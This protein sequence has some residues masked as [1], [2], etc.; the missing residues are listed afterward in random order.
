MLLVNSVQTKTNFRIRI[1]IALLAFLLVNACT[2]SGPVD[3]PDWHIGDGNFYVRIIDVGQASSA[4]ITTPDGYH[5]I[6]DFATGT[7]ATKDILPLLDSLG[8]DIL[9]MAIVSHFDGDHISGSDEVLEV[10]DLAGYCYDHGGTYTTNNFL[11]YE[12]AVGDKRRTMNFGDTL[13]LGND[14]V[15]IA[16]MA[17]GGNGTFVIQENDKSVG[18]IISWEGFDVWIGGDLNGSD[19]GERVDMEGRIADIMPMVEFYV[20]NHHGSRYSSSET[21]LDALQPD[22]CAISCGYDNPYGHPHSETLARLAMWTSEIYRTDLSGT[23][24]VI[25]DDDGSYSISTEDGRYHEVF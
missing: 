14:G 4:L 7:A 19:E 11:E 5:L 12:E 21:F 9:D 24:T 25:V 1:L 18:C 10:I 15:R 17:S 2:D 13:Y 6:Y 20:A 23:I 3:P 8:I 16:C 22:F